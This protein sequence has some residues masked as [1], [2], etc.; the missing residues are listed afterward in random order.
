MP[1]RLRFVAHTAKHPILYN[2]CLEVRN[3]HKYTNCKGVILYT[4]AEVKQD[5]AS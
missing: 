1:W 4:L 5:D 3:K 2:A